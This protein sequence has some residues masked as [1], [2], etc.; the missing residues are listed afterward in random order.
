MSRLTLALPCL[1]ALAACRDPGADAWARARRAHEALIVAGVTPSNPKFD[2]LLA[3]LDQVPA[4]SER[5]AEAQRLK[6]AIAGARVHLRRPLAVAH[7][8]AG[9]IPSQMGAQAQ[10]CARLAEQLGLDGGVTAAGLQALSA[11]Q[12]RV[13]ELDSRCHSEHDG[14]MEP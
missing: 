5:Y 9:D 1:L 3:L 2:E 4:G 11:C 7:D 6:R 10:A 12:R 8:S 13:E 14:G